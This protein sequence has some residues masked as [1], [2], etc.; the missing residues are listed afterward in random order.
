MPSRSRYAVLK[1][2]T[3]SWPALLATLCVVHS[4]FAGAAVSTPVVSCASLTQLA[5]PQTQIISANEITSSPVNYCN[6]VG[7]IG[8][9]VSA[10]DPDHFTYGIGFEL[11]LPDSWIGRFEMQGGSGS[12]GSVSSPMGAAGIELGQGWAVAKDDG[13][14]EDTLPNPFGW[15]DDDANAGGS[16][17]FGIDERARVNYGYKGIKKTATISKA[18]ISHYYGKHASFSY[19]SGCSNG[20]RDGMVASQRSPDL[21]DGIIAGNP[22]FDLPRA[23]IA[24]V[25]NEQSLEPLATRQ[26]IN[27]QPYI[28]DTFP[29]QDLEVASAA[30]LKACDA[31]DGLVDGI[32]DNFPACTDKV[33]FPV[34]HEFTCRAG[35]VHG[36]VPHGGSCLTAGQVSALKRIFAGPKNSR[37]EPLYSS[38]Y[39]DAGIW[40]PP[41]APGPGFLT[42]NVGTVTSAPLA[43]NAINLTLGAGAVPMIFTNPPVVTPVAGPQGQEAFLFK[44]NFDEDAP[45]IF[46]SAPGY[47]E[48][49][50]EFMT[51]VSLNLSPFMR[52]GGKLIIYDS[53]NDGIFSGV[54]IVNWY[55]A[56]NRT[57]GGN[58]DDFARLFM[59]PNMA[60]CGGGP[61][62]NSFG[63]AMLTAITDWVENGVAPDRIVAANTSTASPFPSGGLFDPMVAQNFPTGGTRPL[64]PYPQQSR[65]LGSGSTA[66]EANFACVEPRQ[67]DD[68]E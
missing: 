23:A 20:G 41:N 53:V 17:H 67:Q 48:S 42:W 8:K 38:W 66:D 36:N 64:C 6:V 57:I 13:G 29:P 51:G 30:I 60:H 34:L 32:I 40:D 10:Q 11:N 4:H 50:M 9:Y 43:N 68:R 27:G 33:V 39:W 2:E 16:A 46:E 26:D 44:Y 35:G 45:T 65:Y 49:P 54:D 14:H 21:F 31:L 7:V 19:L 1:A 55:E 22:G 47:P 59:V 28:P 61:A 25:W 58:A 18:I 12:D 3:I 52:H 63:P 5:L 37:G 62:T 56:M 15:T 24:E